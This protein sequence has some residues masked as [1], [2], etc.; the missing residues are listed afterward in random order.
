MTT[1][2]WSDAIARARENAPFLERSLDRLPDLA[3]ILAAG[4]TG[5]A[6]AFCEQ[7]GADQPVGIALRRQRLALAL[8]LA[9]GDLA[10]A[11]TLDDVMQRL[12]AF[13]DL[14]LD[15]AI[16]EAAQARTKLDSVDGFFALA[17][18]K[19]GARELNYSSDIDPILLFDPEVLAEGERST[20]AE[21]AQ[22]MARDIVRLLADHTEEGYVFRVDLRLRPAAEVAPLAVSVNAAAS[23]YG[24]AALAWERAAFI[25]A[26]S[27][28]GDVERGARFLSGIRPFVWRRSLDF[29]TIDDIAQLRVRI[30]EAY[31]GESTLGSGFDLKRGRGGIRE[32]EFF[33]Q[34]HQ[35]IH[36]GRDPRLRSS[37]T[38]AA[39][40]TLAR[41]DIVEE[42]TA[43]RL[44][45]A[46]TRL[47]VVEHRIQML[48][49]RQ[50]HAIPEG[51]ALDR[52][53]RLDGYADGNALLATLEPHLA[54]TARAFDDLLESS[55]TGA[56]EDRPVR[57]L[58]ADSPLA[59][60]GDI[61]DRVANWL[62]GRYRALR[63]TDAQNA[64]RRLLPSLLE[65]L[66]QSAEPDRAIVRLER[67]LEALPSGI[68][69]FRLLEARPALLDQFL[70]IITLAPPL[71]N[72]LALRPALLD[73]LIDR[74][75]LDLPER[76]SSLRSSMMRA[77]PLGNYEALLDRIRVVTGEQRF[78][79]GVQLIGGTHDPLDIARGF[80]TV[81]E[82]ALQAAMAG[83]KAEFARAHGEV[84]GSEMVILGL[85]RLGGEALTHASDLDIVY[86]FTGDYSAESNGERPMGASRYFNRL[87][88]RVSA[89]LSVPT[90]EGPLYE[91][92]TRLR[93]QGAQGPLA[94]SVESFSRYQRE[95]A[96]TWEHMALA[97]ARTVAGSF[98]ARARV[99]D[100]IREVLCAPRD[101][102]T[103]R[104]D[105]L[106]MRAEMAQHKPAKGPLDVKLLRGGLV[107]IEFI[108]HFLQLRDGIALDPRLSKVCETLVHAGELPAEFAQ[109]QDFL[110][111]LIVAARLLAPD[112][113][114]PPGAA[115]EALA[116]A[117]G[118]AGPADL[119]QA[120]AK[121]RQSVAQTW[122]QIFE[123]KLELDR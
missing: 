82:A 98:S 23:H 87:A 83:A 12:S 61:S 86:L 119:L 25:R 28:A 97:R 110:T 89:A 33:A 60:E 35:L 90:A 10:G 76:V 37:D 115:G 96:W 94:V 116:K 80:A 51:E 101:P 43:I 2:G 95:S 103:L 64:F 102:A 78:A 71:A 34:T 73:A 79:L 8:T 106:R 91:V 49:D 39:L 117:C 84:E 24:S 113:S 63:G 93:P 111:R 13:A 123:T 77:E 112:L 59:Q 1:I 58:V 14:A 104:E 20:P 7:A 99:E 53:A 19:H 65:S 67:L 62:D 50:T 41:A 85:G 52:L 16:A 26:R 68:N 69:L 88:Q 108:L 56:A 92:D 18:G 54:A 5:A 15:T 40:L 75:A 9:I 38:R 109:A 6:F 4:D 70:S 36:G 55:R 17:L 72:D 118:C 27:A 114:C 74:S 31:S 66:A 121:A 100:I 45:E 107:D 30:R 29:G 46:Y 32:I 3:A 47:R 122:Q 105:V 42:E 11:F 57:E 44:A 81:A 22:R 120:V 21:T 48:E